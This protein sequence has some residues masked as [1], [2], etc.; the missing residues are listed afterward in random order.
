M[1]RAETYL[2]KLVTRPETAAKKI[3]KIRGHEGREGGWIYTADGRP[4]CQ[5]W[6]EYARRMQGAH[7]IGQD[8]ETGKWYVS[9]VSL[10][11]ADWL[12]AEQL[13]GHSAMSA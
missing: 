7:L 4:I 3:A 12:A 13:F 8:A 11:H 10:P 2:E 1:T 5:G 6:H 9:V